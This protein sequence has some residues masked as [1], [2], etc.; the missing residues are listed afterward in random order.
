MT[1]HQ[2]KKGNRAAAAIVLTVLGAA[3]AWWGIGLRPGEGTSPGA[4]AEKAT[5][6]AAEYAADPAPVVWYEDDGLYL[7]K[8]GKK[9]T[10]KLTGLKDGD[11]LEITVSDATISSGNP[12]TGL[13]LVSMSPTNYI[14][15]IDTTVLTS[16]L[17]NISI[18][19]NA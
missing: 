1:M 13:S 19:L 7:Y 9:E 10:V 16:D 14:V 3:V 6:S 11:Q 12:V 17:T 4:G 8:P 15:K 5:S 2:N 18:T